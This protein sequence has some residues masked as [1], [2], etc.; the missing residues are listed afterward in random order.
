MGKLQAIGANASFAALCQA[1]R[2]E[3]V[4]NSHGGESLK[5]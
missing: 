3:E 1:D 4:Q 5:N 2:E